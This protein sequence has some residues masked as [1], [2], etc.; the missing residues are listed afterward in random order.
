MK[1]FMTVGL[2]GMLLF[3]PSP[4]LY[5]QP[6]CP[7]AWKDL[8]DPASS[9][10]GL[11][12]W[13]NGS[14]IQITFNGTTGFGLSAE[15]AV[16]CGFE[17]WNGV[18]DNYYFYAYGT[19][20]GA[21]PDLMGISNVEF[22]TASGGWAFNDSAL[23]H[24]EAVALPA[25]GGYICTA[26]TWVNMDS[27]L[28]PESRWTLTCESGKF[29][30]SSVA[31]HEAG[32]VLG[33]K[34]PAPENV[35]DDGGCTQ[36]VMRSVL[37]PDQCYSCG[38]LLWD[39]RAIR[40][41]YDGNPAATVAGFA[42]TDGICAWRVTSEHETA[43]YHIEGSSSREGPWLGIASDSAGV[44]EHAVDVSGNTFSYY[45]LVE[46][47]TDGNRRGLGLVR[48]TSTAASVLTPFTPPDAAI[49]RAGLD[50][51][52]TVA[53][54]PASPATISDPCVIF[55]DS[56]FVS[57][58]ESYVAAFWRLRGYDVRVV[59]I[60]GHP[61]DP[62]IF[63]NGLKASITA[64]ADSAG[65][66]YFHLIGDANDWREFDGDLTSSYWV[67][68]WEN[69]R[70]GYLASGY[71]AGGEPQKDV[72]PTFAVPDTAKRGWGQNMT[73][74]VPYYF[75]DQPYADTDND[76]VPDVVLARWPVS[77]S[78]QL[79]TLAWKMQNYNVYGYTAPDGPYAVGMLGYDYNIG[80]IYESFWGWRV[81]AFVDSL[82]AELATM[83]SV[84]Y[85]AY[86]YGTDVAGPPVAGTVTAS[87]WNST[88]PDVAIM[89]ATYSGRYEACGFLNSYCP[90]SYCPANPFDVGLL[91]A[92]HP[93]IVLAGSCGSADWAGTEDPVYGTPVC[94]K[95]LYSYVDR[96]AVAWIG[97]TQGSWLSGNEAVLWHTSDSL[98][99]NPTRPMA[100]SF[101][102]AL[103]GAYQ[104]HAGR[105]RTLR[106]VRS[107]N[108]LGDPLS[109][110]TAP[111][112]AT[113]VRGDSRRAPTRLPSVPIILRQKVDVNLRVVGGQRDGGKDCQSGHRVECRSR[114]GGQTA[115]LL[116]RVQASH[117]GGSGSSATG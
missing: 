12:K 5:G 36:T 49:L 14:C 111:A 38:L 112:I 46:E 3:A 90:N 84:G 115:G 40:E 50:S 45:R 110:L 56:H 114:W 13:Q 58:V 77:E 82:G 74:Y 92:G 19:P 10:E 102:R 85:V 81:R 41:L 51:L 78:W 61:S 117:V 22:V 4:G 30:L 33:L 48:A 23:A 24:T 1:A 47:E 18:S 96:G 25:C 69:V 89:N 63:R 62:D 107:Y 44:G 27:D 16:R 98:L 52:M 87:F 72:I 39:R 60:D 113:A 106:T 105:E 43:R 29:D 99:A 73:H 21:P 104:A 28:R 79:L 83:P 53:R 86:L 80:V 65:A 91:S 20:C 116:G 37:N 54:P 42:A 93:A 55:T 70:Q 67:G 9:P 31:L 66:R 88:R 100:E 26:K 109:P 76:G 34:H 71:A 7:Y 57:D 8:L 75:T 95:L 103:Q 17:T 15:D 11:R 101:L 35:F 108:Y 2:V 6:G 59:T 64:W 32:H 97:P 94:E 68:S